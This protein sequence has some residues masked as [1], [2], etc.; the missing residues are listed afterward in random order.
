MTKL[1]R[2]RA[3]VV[4][5]IV[6]AISASAWGQQMVTLSLDGQITHFYDPG[7]VLTHLVR[8][9]DCL[10]GTYR[11]DLAAQDLNPADPH[12]G[13]YRS[14]NALLNMSIG[15]LPITVSGAGTEVVV[16]DREP[17]QEDVFSI[18][19]TP[20]FFVGEMQ[21][22]DLWINAVDAT[23]STLTSDAL[24][25]RPLRSFREW[26]WLVQGRQGGNYFG[27]EG[28]WTVPEPL[29]LALFLPALLLVRKRRR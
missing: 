13:E 23:G 6:L 21:I 16:I 9:S 18:G 25:E 14:P 15:R 17:G 2:F 7:Y 24:P 26:N 22:L 8:E 5:I 28:T 3:G 19:A 1:G 11:Y 20:A 4:A 10:H 29:T 27:I 12:R